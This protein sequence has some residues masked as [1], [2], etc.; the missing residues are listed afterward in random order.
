MESIKQIFSSFQKKNFVL[1]IIPI[2]GAFGAFEG[3][4]VDTRFVLKLIFRFCTQYVYQKKARKIWFLN[5]EN[6]FIGSKDMTKKTK[7]NWPFF[8]QKSSLWSILVNTCLN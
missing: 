8:N 3:R 2:K 4:Q 1:K 5:Y 7:K 6:R